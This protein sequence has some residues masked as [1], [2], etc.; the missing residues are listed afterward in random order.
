MRHVHLSKADV[1]T[2]FGKGAKLEKER[3]L[4]QPGQFL[5]KQRV[6]LVGTK[7][8]FNNV[9]VIGPERTDSQVEVSRTD[10]F[11][12]GVKDAPLRQSGDTDG[13]PNLVILS[14]DL[15]TQVSA[16]TIL[17]K[18]HVHLDPDTAKKHN[19][20]DGQI[21][22]IQTEGERA[23]ILD[24]VVARVHKNFAPAVHIDTDESNAIFSP[25]TVKICLTNIDKV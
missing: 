4:S 12:L 25:K 22:Q 5:C 6:N 11:A 20:T 23:A 10:A 1:E 14:P 3:E 9:A 17:A 19:I 21:V 13:A 15:A 18:R 16:P 8:S 2:L 7:T 24:Q